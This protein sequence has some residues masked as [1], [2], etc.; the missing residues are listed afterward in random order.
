VTGPNIVERR[1]GAVGEWA[2]SAPCRG[3]YAEWWPRG[4]GRAQQELR[5][6]SVCRGECPVQT[7]CLRYGVLNEEAHGIWGGMLESFWQKIGSP[8]G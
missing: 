7:D 1:L 3:R 5:A 2:E 4:R 8:Y 6:Q